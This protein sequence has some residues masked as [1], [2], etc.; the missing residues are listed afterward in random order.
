MTLEFFAVDVQEE[1]GTLRASRPREL[2]EGNYLHGYDI[3]PSGSFVL[4]LMPS[5]EARDALT[6]F[7][8]PDRIQLVQ[9]WFVELEE[10][11][12]Q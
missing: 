2:F 9:N 4:S 6:E 7:V 3:T 12:P 10:R 1:S 11:A 5:Q 8:M